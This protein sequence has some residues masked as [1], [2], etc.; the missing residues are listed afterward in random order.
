[1]RIEVEN[2]TIYEK[3]NE[4]VFEIAAEQFIGFP[5][6]QTDAYISKKNIE[7]GVFFISTKDKKELITFK[8]MNPEDI[9]KLRNQK[10]VLIALLESENKYK[11]IYQMDIIKIK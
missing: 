8:N 3:E 5:F 4:Q 10:T 7:K 11:N 9:K 6:L 1:M 2:Y